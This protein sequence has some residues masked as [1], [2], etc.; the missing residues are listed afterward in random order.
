MLRGN[1]RALP[2]NVLCVFHASLLVIKFLAALSTN[3]APVSFPF[4]L[5]L[6][7][8]QQPCS[9]KCTLLRNVGGGNSGKFSS[10]GLKAGGSLLPHLNTVHTSEF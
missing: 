4:G 9:D 2:K 7:S 6:F 8:M 1:L 3:G 5:H 10:Q